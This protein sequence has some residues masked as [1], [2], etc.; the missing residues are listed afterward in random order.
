MKLVEGDEY[1]YII[2]NDNDEY[3]L[4]MQIDDEDIDALYKHAKKTGKT[5]EALLR[6]VIDKYMK[7]LG[8]K[9]E[10]KR[11]ISINTIH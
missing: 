11:N 8:A 5:P 3:E 7:S 9:N 4:G 6:D 10:T 2:K 1:G